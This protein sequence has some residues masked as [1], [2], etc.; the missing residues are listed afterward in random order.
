MMMVRSFLF[1]LFVAAVLASINDGPVCGHDHITYDSHAEAKAAGVG[2]MHCGVCGQCSN[3][4]DI[5]IYNATRN[6]LTK[7]TTQCAWAS[8]LIG[9]SVGNWCMN[10]RVGFTDGCEKCWMDNIM[11]DAKDCVMTCIKWKFFHIGEFKHDLDPCLACDEFTCGPA[12]A[13]CAGANR[14][15]SGIISDIARHDE[16]VCTIVDPWPQEQN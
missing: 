13:A 1:A 5:D 7:T 15:R 9:E 4:H 11:C 12:F 2:V 6:T 16:E 14:R 8:L 3:R 10:K